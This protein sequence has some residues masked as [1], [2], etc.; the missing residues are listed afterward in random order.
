MN[1]NPPLLEKIVTPLA[2]LAVGVCFVVWADEVTEWIAVLLGACAVLYALFAFVKFL[3]SAPE[4][5]TTLSLLYIILSFSVGILLVSR[6]SFIK[7]AISFVVGVYVILSSSVSLLNLSS[8][9]RKTGL[10]AGSYIWPVIGL[11]VGFF[12]ITGQFIVP[13]ELARL[14]GAVLVVYALADLIS[15]F[16]LK[17]LKKQAEKDFD[18]ALGI[19]EGKIVKK[20]KQR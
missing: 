14:T 1:N 4:L 20:K 16:T 2:L 18:E 9:R 6:A 13:N 10:P 19:K 5:R 3:K 12:C 11:V 17:S 7:E 15:I 8:L